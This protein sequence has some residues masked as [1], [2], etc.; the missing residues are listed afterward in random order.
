VHLLLR[1]VETLLNGLSY[2]FEWVVRAQL[3]GLET[4]IQ[5]IA[6]FTDLIGPLF[7]LI[8]SEGY[9]SVWCCESNS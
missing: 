2:G 6:S 7:E 4:F 3:R 9:A 1:G 8:N 5:T